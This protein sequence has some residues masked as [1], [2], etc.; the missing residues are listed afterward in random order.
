[1]TLGA[2]AVLVVTKVPTGVVKEAQDGFNPLKTILLVISTSY[3]DHEVRL[4]PPT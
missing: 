3:V 1:M 4:G 2:A